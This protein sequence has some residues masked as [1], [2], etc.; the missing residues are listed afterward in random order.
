MHPTT[1]SLN[2]GCRLLTCVGFVLVR[3]KRSSSSRLELSI[4]NELLHS[5]DDK[6]LVSSVPLRNSSVSDVCICVATVWNSI[7]CLSQGRVYSETC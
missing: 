1:M 7:M 3:M 5:S 4:N 2:N 6:R